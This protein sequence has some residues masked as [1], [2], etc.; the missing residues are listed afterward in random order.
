MLDELGDLADLAI[1]TFRQLL[2]DEK[3]PASV[4]LKAAMEIAKLVES[5]RPSL[6]ETTLTEVKCGPPR[7]RPPVAPGRQYIAYRVPPSGAPSLR[8]RGPQRPL[9]LR[10]LT[11]NKHGPLLGS[12]GTSPGWIRFRGD[13]TTLP[14][15]RPPQAGGASDTGDPELDG[16][17][18]QV[19]PRP[20]TRHLTTFLCYSVL[21]RSLSRR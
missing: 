13:A 3:A 5:Q 21:E 2:S 9:P 19:A 7:E 16:A 14:D 8:Q 1:D 12:S 6:R 20:N 4:R 17:L 11:Q 15:P 10:Q 18:E